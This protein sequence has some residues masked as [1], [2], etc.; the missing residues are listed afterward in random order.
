MQKIIFLT[1]WVFLYSCSISLA[2]TIDFPGKIEITLNGNPASREVLTH[3]IFCLD[4]GDELKITFIP[5]DKDT[6]A[7][8]VLLGLDLW[9]QVNLGRPDLM[10]RIE[11]SAPSWSP[12]VK[13]QLKDLQGKNQVPMGLQATRGSLQLQRILKVE[14]NRMLATY[15]V[16]PNEGSFYLSMVQNCKGE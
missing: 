10:G 9:A 3:Q 1:L 15:P 13:F 7:R 12:S 6:S 2:Q 14:G 5:A 8:Y 16:P 11:K 4:G